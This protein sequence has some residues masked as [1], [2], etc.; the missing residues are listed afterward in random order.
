MR[1]TW[2]KRLVTAIAGLA[3]A[4]AVFASQAKGVK[5]VG[6]VVDCCVYDQG[7]HGAEDATVTINNGELSQANILAHVGPYEGEEAP[8][9]PP[10]EAGQMYVAVN[11]SVVDETGVPSTAS[12]SFEYEGETYSGTVSLG[13]SWTGMQYGGGVYI[14]YGPTTDDDDDDDAD[15]PSSDSGSSSKKDDSSSSSP[16]THHAHVHH[17]V[18][19][20]ITPA[21]ETSDGLMALKCDGKKCNLIDHSSEVVIPRQSVTANK[22]M[23]LITNA[24]AGEPIV[25]DTKDSYSFNQYVIAEL[26]KHPECPVTWNF[27][28]EN[29]SYTM[30]VPAGTDWT[31][32]LND[33]SWAGFKNVAALNGVS[34]VENSK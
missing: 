21:T 17:M 25:L 9:D 24:K 27:T 34:L 19:T 16:S 12:F 18:M 8:Y 6:A 23:Q 2:K 26:M 33:K 30:T 5:A 7:E 3:L 28:Y 20:V 13:A 15:S 14:D 22:N 4:G 1:K 29:K 10:V 32:A 31:A 11:L